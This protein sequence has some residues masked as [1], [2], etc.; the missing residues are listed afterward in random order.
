MAVSRADA[1]GAPDCFRRRLDLCP[2]DDDGNADEDIRHR[3]L[4]MRPS[5]FRCFWDVGRPPASAFG[6]AVLL[7]ASS[8]RLPGRRPAAARNDY[9]VRL[10]G[11]RRSIRAA[12]CRVRL[13]EAVMMIVAAATAIEA[14]QSARAVWIDTVNGHVAL[15]VAQ[16]GQWMC[17]N[18]SATAVGMLIE[19]ER[20]HWGRLLQVTAGSAADADLHPV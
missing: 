20:D 13:A 1:A 6:F 9:G 10:H 17:P 5:P 12:F 8:L 15:C 2:A 11:S 7:L 18:R 16:N 3:R 14:A 19:I 4:T